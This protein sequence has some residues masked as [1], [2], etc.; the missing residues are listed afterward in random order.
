ML[1]LGEASYKVYD[2][3]VTTSATFLLIWN[4]SKFLK[5]WSRPWHLSLSLGLT[6]RRPEDNGLPHCCDAS[7][8][9]RPFVQVYGMGGHY[10]T[11][12]YSAASK[13]NKPEQVEKE[14]LRVEQILKEPKIDAPISKPY[15]NH[16]VLFKWKA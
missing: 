15:V 5:P 4:Y 10:S 9:L 3:S 7:A 12:L 13:Q 16:S 8:H 6:Y 14:L 1:T 11:V 2:N